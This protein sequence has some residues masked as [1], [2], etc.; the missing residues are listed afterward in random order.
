METFALYETPTGRI[1]LSGII[2]LEGDQKL[3]DDGEEITLLG[4]INKRLEDDPDLAVRYGS[5]DPPDPEEFVI[6]IES[7]EPRKA[8]ETEKEQ[9]PNR[10]RRARKKEAQGRMHNFAGMKHT[11]VDAWLDRVFAE[12]PEKEADA[13]KW[14][15][16]R[17]TNV[18]SAKRAMK[19]IVAALY[20]QRKATR[21][22]AHVL[23][24]VIRRLDW[25][26]STE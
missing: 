9:T 14:T 19:K 6:D 11:D 5:G 23:L 2:D 22:L 15:D 16:D 20:D 24:A 1:R 7:G 18:A 26:E 25:D 21:K 17:V 3:I 12:L 8:T 10:R 13:K 4:H